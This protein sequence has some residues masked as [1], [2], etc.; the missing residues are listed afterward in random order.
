[1][2]PCSCRG[3]LHSAVTGLRRLCGCHED[4][5]DVGCQGTGL[6]YSHV[7]LF[8]SDYSLYAQAPWRVGSTHGRWR[9]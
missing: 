9:R 1:M 7:G 2:S 6:D 8:G 3:T 5:E 4:D